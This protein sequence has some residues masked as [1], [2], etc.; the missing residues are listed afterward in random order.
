MCIVGVS[1]DEDLYTEKSACVSV[2]F[3]FKS[4]YGNAAEF[5]QVQYPMIRLHL[6]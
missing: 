2:L 6:I 1:G 4:A 5:F 3:E